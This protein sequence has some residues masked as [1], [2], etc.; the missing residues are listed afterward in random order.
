MPHLY[1]INE[2]HVLCRYDLLHFFSIEPEGCMT[3]G[4]YDLLHTSV[5][6]RLLLKVLLTNQ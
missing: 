5:K 6:S 1:T 4:R 2:K 3:C